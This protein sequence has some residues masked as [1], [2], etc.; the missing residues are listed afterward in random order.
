METIPKLGKS[1]DKQ[2]Q[3]QKCLLL[4]ASLRTNYN[5]KLQVTY[6]KV[7]DSWQ[8]FSF[9]TTLVDFF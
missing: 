7:K 1:D 2:I 9:S 8:I 3:V 4:I 6:W 5:G